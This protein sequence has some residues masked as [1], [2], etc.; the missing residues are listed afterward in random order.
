MAVIETRPSA[1]EP[2]FKVVRIEDGKYKSIYTGSDADSGRINLEMEYAIGRVSTAISPRGIFLYHTAHAAFMHYRIHG[3]E[4][5]AKV[6]RPYER[7]KLP[8]AVLECYPIGDPVQDGEYEVMYMEVLP[9]G[10]VFREEY[11]W[12]DVTKQC[13]FTLTDGASEEEGFFYLTI[14]HNGNFV[15]AFGDK[16][17]GAWVENGYQVEFSMCTHPNWSD[18]ANFRVMKVED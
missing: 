13:E 10:E 11:E 4:H 12:K 2:V 14:R 15:G 18:F 17:R 9:V 3:K 8:L 6:S 16:F 7:S 5:E 1:I